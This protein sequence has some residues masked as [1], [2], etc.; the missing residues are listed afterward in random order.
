[1][2]QAVVRT[3]VKVASLHRLIVLRSRGGPNFSAAP[4]SRGA[5]W[6]CDADQRAAA[7]RLFSASWSRYAA[8][9]VLGQPMSCDAELGVDAQALYGAIEAALDI[10]R[11]AASASVAL[12]ARALERA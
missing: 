3:S 11:D 7:P 2:S 12:P 10:P 8:R 9:S 1:M 5:V 4:P 6:L